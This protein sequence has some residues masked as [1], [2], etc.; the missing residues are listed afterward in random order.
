MD[1]EAASIALFRTHEQRMLDAHRRRMDV[2]VLLV[3][4]ALGAGKTT[5]LNHILTNKL[6]LRVTVLVNDLSSLNID[7]DMLVHEN[8]SEKTVRLSNG[9]A[10][11]TLLG[12][13][14]DELWHVLQS[15]GDDRLDY[16]VIEMSGVVTDPS[17]VIQSLERRYGMMTRTRLDG[18]VVVVDGDVFSHQL[19]TVHNQVSTAEEEAARLVRSAAGEAFWHQLEWADTML[20]NKADLIGQERVSRLCELVAARRRGCARC[21]A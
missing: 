17:A 16:V 6:N 10:C 5:L 11:H 7:A 2:P 19:D 20:V 1:F 3:G 15:S 9:C 18:V 8:A 13:M 12:E 4:G 14:E 21:P